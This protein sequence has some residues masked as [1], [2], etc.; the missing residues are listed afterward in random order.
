SEMPQWMASDGEAM[1]RRRWLQQAAAVLTGALAARPL[2]AASRQA[3]GALSARLFPGFETHQIQTSGATINAV[4]GGQGPPVL[5]LHGAPQSHITWRGV[6]PRLAED[7]T[8]VAADLRG[9]GDSS[10]PEGEPD[11]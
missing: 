1:D 11:H 3:P 9:Y 6:A 4:V 5:L 10:K 7:Y 8:V 2:S